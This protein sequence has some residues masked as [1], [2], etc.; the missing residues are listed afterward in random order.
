MMDAMIPVL[1][2][3]NPQEFIDLGLFG[4][5]WNIPMSD[6]AMPTRLW[7]GTAD[8]NVPL[9]AAR[10]L[11]EMLPACSTETL[12]GEGHLWVAQ[13]YDEVLAWIARAM[14]GDPRDAGA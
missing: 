1:A 7:L 8:R 13:H 11:A 3:A 2:P 12:P 5:P 6:A 9:G 10:R 4:S 14:H